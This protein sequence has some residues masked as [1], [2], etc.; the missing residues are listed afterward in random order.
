MLI[1]VLLWIV[2]GLV[3]GVIARAVM[4]G[5]QSMGFIATTLLGI[6]GSFVGG[7][8]ATL[9]TGGFGAHHGVWHPVGFLGSLLGAILILAV[10]GLS[11]R[12]MT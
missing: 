6:V 12:R 4:P 9:F 10:A 2:F 3:V 7:F 8:I 1:T 5:T 11:R